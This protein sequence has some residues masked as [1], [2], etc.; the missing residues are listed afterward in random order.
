MRKIPSLASKTLSVEECY[1]NCRALLT[2]L[3]ESSP[4]MQRWRIRRLKT[5]LPTVRAPIAKPSS[6]D[7][8]MM[9]SGSSVDSDEM[10][11]HFPSQS[12]S[13]VYEN[14]MD[15]IDRKNVQCQTQNTSK[16]D[17]CIQVNIANTLK[18][19]NVLL[20]ERRKHVFMQDAETN[21]DDSEVISHC[22]F[23]ASTNQS[24]GRKKP[25]MFVCDLTDVVMNESVSSSTRSLVNHDG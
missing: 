18:S 4:T 20:S 6:P 23:I 14:I 7:S 22:D 3:N 21:T 13:C 16:K 8:A 11:G 19:P 25:F 10:H 17:V 2:T 5:P 1:E 24:K 15:L 12:P 9:T